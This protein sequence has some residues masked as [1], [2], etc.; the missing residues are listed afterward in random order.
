M[1]STVFK[2]ASIDRSDNPPKVFGEGGTRTP[3][4]FT[5]ATFEVAALPLDDFSI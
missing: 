2:T 3:T 5:T 1:P 4:W